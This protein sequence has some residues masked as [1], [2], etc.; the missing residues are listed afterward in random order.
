MTV[1][2][3]NICGSAG[4]LAIDSVSVFSFSKGLRRV[5]FS[6]SM[7][8]VEHVYPKYDYSDYEEVQIL[9]ESD[10]GLERNDSFSKG[11]GNSGLSQ[12]LHPFLRPSDSVSADPYHYNPSPIKNQT[13]PPATD[14][15]RYT[16]RLLSN[17]GDALE[18]HLSGNYWTSSPLKETRDNV[19]ESEDIMPAPEDQASDFYATLNSDVAA[20]LW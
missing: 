18:Q 12:K 17:F 20:L 14:I 15:H 13:S 4:G 8:H 11:I 19:S 5:S 7:L 9:E 10:G 16:P 1:T 6:D 3:A 2:T